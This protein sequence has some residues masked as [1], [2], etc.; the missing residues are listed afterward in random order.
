MEFWDI[1]LTE[2]WVG[3]IK[4]M[5]YIIEV[6]RNELIELSY[7]ETLNFFNDIRENKVII[8]KLES[9]CFKDFIARFVFDEELLCELE[10]QY[11]EIKENNV[12]L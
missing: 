5:L 10:F 11:K 12:K 4:C 9:L 3:V 8:K 2:K 6:C 7:S 1:I